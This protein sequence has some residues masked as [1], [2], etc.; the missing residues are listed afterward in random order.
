M[1]VEAI[2]LTI[3]V[4]PGLGF[5]GITGQPDVEKRQVVGELQ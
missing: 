4:W 5:G 3:R 1:A 2:A